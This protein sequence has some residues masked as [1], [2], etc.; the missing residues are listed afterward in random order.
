P[1]HS[2]AVRT[3]TTTAIA[4]VRARSGA[5]ARISAP[6]GIPTKDATTTVAIGR[7][8]RSARHRIVFHRVIGTPIAVTATTATFGSSATAMIGTATS[9]NPNPIVDWIAAAKATVAAITTSRVIS[10]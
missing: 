3:R 6:T 5:R 1:R 9:A 10:L 8:W 4:N 2:H 7:T